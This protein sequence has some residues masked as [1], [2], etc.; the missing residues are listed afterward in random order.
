MTWVMREAAG[1][2]TCVRTVAARTA[3]E[4]MGFFLSSDTNE[5]PPKKI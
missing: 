4:S 1:G 5:G 2:E 3:S